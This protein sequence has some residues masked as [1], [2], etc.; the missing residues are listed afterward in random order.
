M[1]PNPGQEPVSSEFNSNPLSRSY[2]EAGEAVGT[3]KQFS[4]VEGRIP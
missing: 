3:K 1:E 4:T 2:G